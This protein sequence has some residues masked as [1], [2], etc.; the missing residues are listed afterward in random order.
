MTSTTSIAST[1]RPELT[2]VASVA[3]RFAVPRLVGATPDGAR[4][5][6]MVQGA[7]SGPA[8]NGRFPEWAAYLLV[9]RDGIGT[10][11]VRAPL[12][13]DD[14]AVAELESKGRYDFGEDGYR[15]ALAKDLP[16][17]ALG[18]C[19]RFVTGDARYLWL[20]RVV[21]VGVGELRPLETRIDYAL[22]SLRA[23]DAPHP[24]VGPAAVVE[25][26]LYERLGGRAVTDRIADDFFETLITNVRLS[27]QNPRAAVLHTS[28]QPAAKREAMRST[29]DLLCS[30]TGGPCSYHGPS[31]QDAH[32]QLGITAADWALMQE[33]FE[34]VLDRQGVRGSERRELVAVVEATRP[35]IVRDASSAAAAPAPWLR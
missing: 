25:P 30:L 18:W 32:A 4:F 34:R 1:A 2:F 7:V 13:L 17:S 29:R 33:D 8:L 16:N 28:L 19:P 9:D 22:Y 21:H 3:L 12:L 5:H 23:G 26:S 6:F 14:G 35:Q 10:I 11:D 31:M 20:N 15:R 27:R 24:R